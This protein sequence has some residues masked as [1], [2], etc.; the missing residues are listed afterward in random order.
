MA[1]T[2]AKIRNN[3]T[4]QQ[5]Q[6]NVINVQRKPKTKKVVIIPRNTA[7]EE[8]LSA[9]YNES[10]AIVIA[11]GPAGT[12]KTL[13]ATLFAI[14]QFQLG[15][16]ERIVISRPNV[17]VDDRDIGFLKGSLVDKTL[18]WMLPVVELFWDH[19]GKIETERMMEAG[20]IEIIPLAY[21]RG[22][23]LKNCVA[24]FD[25][26]QGTT[27]NSMKAVLTRVGD[28]CKL[29]ITGDVNQ[30]DHGHT[31]GLTDFLKRFEKSPKKGIHIA[32]FN[33]SHCVRHP[34]ISSILNL[35]D[36]E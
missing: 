10:N 29:I 8:Y 12:G 34:I 35:Y 9:L 31:N 11:S 21:I 27:P 16:I 30:S 4:A 20:D 22:R 15:N 18:P 24:I 33:K 28:N 6:L 23:T 7:Q 17:A 26:A 13:I 14:E 25:E 2:S 19:F 36:E 3:R 32:H 1:K 5:P